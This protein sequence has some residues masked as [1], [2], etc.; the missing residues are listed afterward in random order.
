MPEPVM[1]KLGKNT[2]QNLLFFRFANHFSS[3]YGTGSSFESVQ[4]TLAENF[5]VEGRGQCSSACC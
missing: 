3:R 4:I 2:V 1:D 5:G